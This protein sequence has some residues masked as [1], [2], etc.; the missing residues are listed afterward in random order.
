MCTWAG[1]S[2]QQVSIHP[3]ISAF[4][5]YWARLRL[6]P[7]LLPLLPPLLHI[8]LHSLL[9]IRLHSP[10]HPYRPIRQLTPTRQ[11]QLTPPLLPIR[12]RI[13]PQ[14]PILLPSRLSRLRS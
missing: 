6:P 10:T 12:L 11:Y 7:P 9:H 13:H 1:T 5:I 14:L 4:G 8:R 3:T 2:P